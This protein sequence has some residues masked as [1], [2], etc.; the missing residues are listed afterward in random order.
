MKVGGQFCP[1]VLHAVSAKDG[2]LIRIRV[3]GGLIEADQLKAVA[4]LSRAFAD[5]YLE[6][7]S[8]ANL[9]LRGIQDRDLESIVERIAMAGLLPSPQHDRVRNIVTSPIAGLDSEEV[10]DPRPLIHELDEQ[11]RE[12]KVFL[13]LHPKFSFAI[14]G[15]TRRF[16]RSSDDIS[17]EVLALNSIPY[18]RFLIGGVYSGFVVRPEDVVD[19]MLVAAKM[20]IHLATESNLP[21][22]GKAVV[23]LPGAMKLIVDALSHMLMSSDVSPASRLVEEALVGIYPTP[24]N[25]R[26]SIIP[27]VPLGRLTAEQAIYLADVANEWK[28]DLR[29][30]PWRGVVLGSI[31]KS[32]ID[33]IVSHLYS[34]GLSCDGQDGFRGITACAGSSGCEASL[35]DVRSDAAAL[36]QRLSGHAVPSGWTVNFSGCEKQC[37]RRGGAT[38]EL[39]A[40]PSGYALNIAGSHVASD[41]SPEF[42]LESVAAQ[43][44]KMLSEVAVQ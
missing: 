22:R 8:R 34:I 10:I 36:A 12:E 44:K 35:A 43:H 30:S 38:A 14:Y 31:P 29:L 2:L 11:L 15:G 18:F 32:V 6:I 16:S 24:Q 21:V 28:S 23:M 7:T 42:A 17:L 27:S 5:G 26:V 37:A 33:N 25:E 1:G 4:G 40:G 19:C 3:P 13:D 9:Q 20:C 41:C 39:I